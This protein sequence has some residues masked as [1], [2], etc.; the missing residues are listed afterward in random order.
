VEDTILAE[1]TAAVTVKTTTI[2]ITH[3]RLTDHAATHTPHHLMGIAIHH[4]RD[5]QE[6]QGEEVVVVVVVAVAVEAEVAAVEDPQVT[7]VMVLLH[8]LILE[9]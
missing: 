1:T 8:Q 3:N 7:E 4:R 6:D 5:P 9:E 2:T